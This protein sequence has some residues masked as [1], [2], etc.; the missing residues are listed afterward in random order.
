MSDICYLG[1]RVDEF[2]QVRHTKVFADGRDGGNPCPVVLDA[3]DLEAEEMRAIAEHFGEECGFVTS[4]AEEESI[5]LR[6]FVP[7]HEMSMC[8][9]AT[10]AATAVLHLLGR[11]PDRTAVVTT[12]TGPLRVQLEVA[13][14]PRVAVEQL[15]PTFFEDRRPP[16]HEICEVLGIGPEALGAPELPIESVSVSRPKLI[17][18]MRS[19]EVLDA[20]TPDFDALRWLC[21]EYE[22][23][24]LYPFAFGSDGLEARQFPAS[25][26]YDEDAATGV[27]AGAL[28]AYV[29]RY[30]SGFEHRS[31]M[32]I[33]Q[34]RAMGRPSLI[35]ARVAGSAAAPRAEVRGEVT[36]GSVE[37]LARDRFVRSTR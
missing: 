4:G 21:K 29:T 12:P 30:A 22:T 24:G 11:L 6:Y 23:T 9:H 13:E 1:V 3:G 28:A 36:V 37:L 35:E 10:A 18:P 15:A 31:W 2:I 8:V 5:A 33:R 19:P 34:G 25:S 27:A 14:R 16:R 20:L 32:A 7:H 26:G 17:V